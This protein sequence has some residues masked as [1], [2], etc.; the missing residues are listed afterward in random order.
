MDKP[1]GERIKF[2]DTFGQ[3]VT[4]WTNYIKLSRKEN[5]TASEKEQKQRYEIDY[6]LIIKA[7]EYYKIHKLLSEN[8][9]KSGYNSLNLE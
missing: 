5:L 1:E 3:E 4:E 7:N 9:N 6:P 8:E 2:T